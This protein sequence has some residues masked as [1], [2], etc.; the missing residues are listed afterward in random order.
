[1]Y[2][3]NELP[4]RAGYYWR[5]FPVPEP[6][7]DNTIA[8]GAVD[9]MSV[10]IRITYDPHDDPYGTTPYQTTLC[11]SLEIIHDEWRDAKGVDPRSLWYG[12]VELPYPPP[13]PGCTNLF[14]I[15]RNTPTD[16]GK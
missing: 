16:P 11:R 2:W 15:S 13:W 8:D 5:V 4:T 1:M 12:P 7:G 6:H 9:F 10:Q 14:F 3:T